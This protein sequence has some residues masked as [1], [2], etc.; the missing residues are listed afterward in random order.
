MKRVKVGVIIALLLLNF[1][2]YADAWKAVFK[3]LDKKD[4]QKAHTL[5][6]K[7][8]K[9]DPNNVAAHY[10]YAIIYS[11][12]EYDQ[13]DPEKAY[14]F[15]QQALAHFDQYPTRK[16]NG[17]IRQAPL[18]NPLYEDESGEFSKVVV[19]RLS[20][21]VDS[22]CLAYSVEKKDLNALEDYIAKHK[23]SPYLSKAYLLRDQ[24]A[25]EQA[26]KTN[27]WQAFKKY[28]EQY[29]DAWLAADAEV[30]YNELFFEDMTKAK[31][32]ETY[33]SFAEQYPKSPYA[34]WSKIV[35][36]KKHYE[37]WVRSGN[38]ISYLSYCEKFPYRTWADEAH[39]TYHAALYDSLVRDSQHESYRA[40]AE[41]YPAS[42]LAALAMERWEKMQFKHYTATGT[43]QSYK[44]FYQQFPESIYAAQAREFYKE[45]LFAELV[46]DEPQLQGCQKFLALCDDK[47]SSYYAYAERLVFELSTSPY[48]ALSYQQ[49]IR[50]YPGSPYVAEARKKLK[51]INALITRNKEKAIQETL[52]HKMRAYSRF[53]LAKLNSYEEC[54]IS[55]HLT[56]AYQEHEQ[57]S[58]A[59]G[60]GNDF[61]IIRFMASGCEAGTI[62]MIYKS[63]QL[64]GKYEIKQEGELLIQM[65]NGAF[66][67]ARLN[68][69][70]TIS[71]KNEETGEV[72]F[73]PFDHASLS[74]R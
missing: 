14:H 35:A 49:F 15:S 16:L 56:K 52:Q 44:N 36:E 25:Y 53:G 60:K 57:R 7:E 18:D 22:L 69:D 65:E 11:S 4:Y 26:S 20:T 47:N 30:K 29:P 13:F 48:N 43:S 55:A 6:E 5:L 33:Q 8:V 66:N 19:E 59:T 40:Y 68:N 62:S 41:S 23:E 51:D 21:T 72:M 67:Q 9:K 61:S 31:T 70:G 12:E 63:G 24:L 10:V 73:M 38:V 58:F 28:T 74:S 50:Q 45:A 34:A 64:K 54:E 3:C 71:L 17:F 32:W 27:T 42:P 2:A 37:E 46:G 1:Q 39:Y